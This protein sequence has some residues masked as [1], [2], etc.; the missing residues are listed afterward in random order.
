MAFAGKS[1][2]RPS[3][4]MAA[5]EGQGRRRLMGGASGGG[6]SELQLAPR[7]H[8]AGTPFEAMLQRTKGRGVREPAQLFQKP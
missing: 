3:P 8:L 5:R 6:G 2:G 1:G 7:S 4:L